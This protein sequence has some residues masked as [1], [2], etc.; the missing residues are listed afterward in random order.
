[1]EHEHLAHDIAHCLLMQDF[2]RLADL[3]EQRDNQLDL[4]Q[5]VEALS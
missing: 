2:D 1:M 5:S 3:I 4:E